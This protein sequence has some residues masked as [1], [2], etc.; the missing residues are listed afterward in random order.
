MRVCRLAVTVTLISSL[1]LITGCATVEVPRIDPQFEAIKPD[2]AW[3]A[4]LSQFV[5]KRGRVDFQGLAKARQKLD[6]YVNYI[7][8]NGPRTNPDKFTAPETRL[9]H[10]LNSYNAL[11]MFNVLDSGIPESLSGF[12]KVRFFYFKKFW[13]DGDRMSLYAY[14]NDII[15]RVGEERVHF[16]LNCMSAGCPRLPQTPFP[17]VGLDKILQSQALEF[18]NEERNVQIDPVKQVVRL[19]EI[20][21]FFTDDFLKKS[22]TL[23]HYV[24]QYRKNKIPDD[25]QVDFIPYDWTVNAS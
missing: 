24:N 4:V 18:F 3:K 2:E 19:S 25:Y 12:K 7:A 23:I 10:Y 8:Q 22:P 6:L 5:D 21:K 15:R 11:S 1:A 9:A 16:A 14:E 20:L 17:Q 13:I